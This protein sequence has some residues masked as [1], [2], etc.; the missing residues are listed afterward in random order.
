MN[1]NL[2]ATNYYK[3]FLLDFAKEAT[4]EEVADFERQLSIFAAE[5]LKA[6]MLL[7]FTEAD[8]QGIETIED[9]ALAQDEIKKLF[10]EKTKLTPE[11]FLHIFREKFAEGYLK[12]QSS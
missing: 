5:E 8:M 2:V 10:K 1:A 6:T 7:L 12:L 11:E 4:P 9:E 3:D